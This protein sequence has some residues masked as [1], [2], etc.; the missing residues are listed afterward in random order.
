[1]RHDQPRAAPWLQQWFDVQRHALSA[2]VARTESPAEALLA[3]A[4]LCEPD[5]RGG[6]F[7]APGLHYRLTAQHEVD[8]SSR[9][10]DFAVTLRDHRI[11]VEVDG[12]EHHDVTPVLAAATKVRARE[13]TALGWEVM[14]FG[15][16]DISRDPRRAAG[17]VRRRVTALAERPAPPLPTHETPVKLSPTLASLADRRPEER[18]GVALLCV[19]LE[20]PALVHVPAIRSALAGVKGPVAIAAAALEGAVSPRGDLDRRAFLMTCPA[21]VQPHALEALAGTALS[22][23][24]T[25]LPRALALVDQIARGG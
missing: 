16:V 7:F 14:P 15:A 12:F 19:A 17:E 9:R 18:A 1:M 3:T 23:P 4:L 6:F 11:A 24:A 2:M 10:V 13:L 25:V 22:N 21:M 20:Q 8:G 5:G